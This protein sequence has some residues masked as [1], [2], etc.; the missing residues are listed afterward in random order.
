MSLHV[1]TV[2]ASGDLVLK[3][4]FRKFEQMRLCLLFHNIRSARWRYL[5]AAVFS[6]SY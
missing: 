1:L 3:N 6:A 5:K 4:T 2:I